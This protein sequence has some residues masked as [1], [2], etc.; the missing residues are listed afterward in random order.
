[1]HSSLNNKMGNITDKFSL[2][3]SKQKS[4]CEQQ[5][6]FENEINENIIHKDNN[7][8]E[9][10]IVNET[11]VT[12]TISKEVETLTCLQEFDKILDNVCKQSEHID[13][14]TQYNIEIDIEGV[15]LE[16][17]LNTPG[18]IDNFGNFQNIFDD[19]VKNTE[20]N[21]VQ[22]I[23]NNEESRNGN[24]NSEI[25]VN[26]S[27][28]LNVNNHLSWNSIYEDFANIINDIAPVAEDDLENTNVKCNKNG[29]DE[30]SVLKN[31]NTYYLNNDTR[32]DWSPKT[33]AFSKTNFQNEKYNPTDS[34]R[35]NTNKF[36]KEYKEKDIN[37]I[38]QTNNIRLD[39]NNM[40][41]AV[42]N[43]NEVPNKMNKNE[44]VILIS[45]DEDPLEIVECNIP[46]NKKP[47]D[48]SNFAN[49]ECRNIPANRNPNSE[50]L[51]KQELESNN[52]NLDAHKNLFNTTNEFR[53]P[54][55][56]AINKNYTETNEYEKPEIVSSN[57]CYI[58]VS[59]TKE[60]I[61][62]NELV[63]EESESS[64]SECLDMH[65]QPT[66]T[67]ELVKQ[68]VDSDCDGYHSSD[69]EFI[70]EDTA[71][72][73]PNFKLHFNE[74]DYV[75]ATNGTN[76]GFN[77]EVFSEISNENGVALPLPNIGTLFAIHDNQKPINFKEFCDEND[78]IYDYFISLEPTANANEFDN[79]SRDSHRI[80]NEEEF[81]NLFVGN[82]IHY[83]MD[84]FENKATCR[85]NMTLDIHGGFA[86][87]M[88]NMLK[89]ESTPEERREAKETE[90]KMLSTY[91]T[92]NRRYRN[93][94]NKYNLRKRCL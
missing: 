44:T 48:T 71:R 73:G 53:N 83:P 2:K 77:F 31:D 6:N 45:D 57:M 51:A 10:N 75:E 39:I 28:H 29:L 1:M 49:S 50:E 86:M 80:P 66:N 34:L 78:M 22:H 55:L 26:N 64:N 4:E 58:E 82:F 14:N 19:F 5:I 24:V 17:D 42:K 70:D 8:T 63:K 21:T 52:E 23:N 7:P 37:M 56:E 54:E 18:D 20:S 89:D 46:I 85:N 15:N 33:S 76:N 62:A 43:R 30:L 68:E 69:F 11:T 12:N 3:N 32:I 27:E 36:K 9:R 60:P 92:E 35:N 74:S 94:N 81:L 87:N 67:N 88:I 38:K 40:F 91:P 47:T 61:N 13:I 59:A 41:N 93:D 16:T 25:S 90:L 72:N 79:S 65:K 84:G